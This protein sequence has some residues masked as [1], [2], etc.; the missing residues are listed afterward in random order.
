[1]QIKE[2]IKEIKLSKQIRQI[3]Q[4]K[5][6]ISQ[7]VQSHYEENPY[8]RWSNIE[9]LSEEVKKSCAEVINSEI[10]PNSI[11]HKIKHKQLN[12]LIAGC[13]SIKY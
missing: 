3:G 9:K 12:V 7:K 6:S 10:Q 4:V 5:N 11:I 13:N 2:P 8:P 1:M